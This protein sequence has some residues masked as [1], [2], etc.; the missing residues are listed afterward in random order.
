MKN[1]FKYLVHTAV[2]YNRY[3][4]LGVDSIQERTHM[5]IRVQQPLLTCSIDNRI[6]I[7]A[8]QV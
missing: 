1:K 5:H 8:I 4:V 6:M 3:N 7:Q 2:S